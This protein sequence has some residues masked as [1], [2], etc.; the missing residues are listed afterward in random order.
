MGED[1]H[2]PVRVLVMTR[3]GIGIERWPAADFGFPST[4]LPPTWVMERRTRM[5]RAY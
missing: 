4:S 5:R 2:D 3:S 1:R